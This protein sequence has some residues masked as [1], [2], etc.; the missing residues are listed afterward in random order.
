MAR[1]DQHRDFLAAEY[2]QFEKY[3]LSKEKVSTCLN[4][5][6]G[7]SGSL[8]LDKSTHACKEERHCT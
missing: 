5:S 2:N 1:K 3:A 6:I 7:V 8:F 4:N